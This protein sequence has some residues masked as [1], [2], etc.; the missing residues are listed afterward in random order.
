MFV[1]IC[2]LE[3]N[4]THRRLD[5]SHL[6]GP[7]WNLVGPPALVAPL[8][9]YGLPWALVGSC[10]PGPCGPG[11]CGQGPCG[12]PWAL[13]GAAGALWAGPV[14]VE[15]LYASCGLGHCMAC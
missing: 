7:L 1:I 11:P 4:P 12:L 3:V 10:G 13:V 6:A 2:D 9:P 15:P 14:W 8:G 5:I